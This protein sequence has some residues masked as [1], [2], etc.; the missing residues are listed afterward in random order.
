MVERYPVPRPALREALLNA[1][2]HRDYMTPAPIQ[3]RVYDHK[4]MLWNPATLPEGWTADTLL[5]THTS[6]PFNPDIANA[7]FRAGEIEA[8]GRGIERICAACR[9]AGAPLPRL[10]FIGNALLTE[11]SFSDEYLRLMATAPPEVSTKTPTK[12]PTK[13]A[14]RVLSLLGGQPALTLNEAAVILKMSPSAVARAAKKLREEG[15]LRYVGP[16]KGGH[17][18]IM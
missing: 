15:R 7:F 1:L 5:A 10:H 6:Q 4:L 9:E 3:I 2:I 8:W 12:T 18:E 13:T 17:W 16:Q 14:E 11:F